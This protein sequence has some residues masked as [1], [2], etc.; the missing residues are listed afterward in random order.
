MTGFELTGEMTATG[1][2][3]RIRR[4]AFGGFKRFFVEKNPA[5]R[6]CCE[7]DDQLNPVGNCIIYKGEWLD[8]DA[9]EIAT[10]FACTHCVGTL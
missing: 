3:V 4:D 7:V 10:D 9:V 6:I 1:S 2:I 5:Q 8:A